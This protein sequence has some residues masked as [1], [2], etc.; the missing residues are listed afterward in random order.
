MRVLPVS[1][2]PSAGVILFVGSGGAALGRLR[3]LRAAGAHVRWLSASADIAEE[4]LTLAGARPGRLEISVGDPLKADLTGV[5][6]IVASAGR[7]VDPQIAERARRHRI[8][9][10]MVDRP[11]L[12]TFVFPASGD[13]GDDLEALARAGVPVRLVPG[14]VPARE[15]A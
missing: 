7:K 8:P 11:D 5:V 4:A 14:A 12:S 1:I 9:V 10:H 6:A 13:R 15:V 3:L 2:D